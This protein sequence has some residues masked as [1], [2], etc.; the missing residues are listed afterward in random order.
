[1]SDNGSPSG[2]KNKLQKGKTF[3]YEP[4]KKT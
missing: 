2:G 1:M 4:A 3:S